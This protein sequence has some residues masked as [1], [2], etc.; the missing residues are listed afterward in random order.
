MHRAAANVDAVAACRDRPG[1][2]ERIDADRAAA[3]REGG[4]PAHGDGAE[5]DGIDGRQREIAARSDGVAADRT[6]RSRDD[7][8]ERVEVGEDRITRLGADAA[9]AAGDAIVKVVRK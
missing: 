9:V 1:G 8:V 5:I 7:V 2:V 3:A 6:R 4:R